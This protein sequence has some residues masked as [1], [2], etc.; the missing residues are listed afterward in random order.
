[1]STVQ[2]TR[3]IV[4]VSG[5]FLRYPGTGTGRYAQMVIDRLARSEQLDARVVTDGRPA[6][7]GDGA[8]TGSRIKWVQAPSLPDGAGQYAR[9]L[10]WEQVG[11]RYAAWRIGARV[12]YSPHFSAPWMGPGATV[13]SIHDLIPLTEPGYAEGLPARLYFKLVSA[14]ARQAA[15]VLTL[16]E[17]A[18]KDIERLLHIPAS[19][20]HVV[21]PGIDET[22]TDTRDAIAEA[23]ARSRYQL[24]PRYLLYVGGADARKNIGVLLEAMAILREEPGILPLIIAAAQPK[25]GQA[26]LFPDWRAQAARLHLGDTVRFIERI[27]EEDLATVYRM[28]SCFCFPSRAE[29]F[30]LPPLEAMACGAPVVC[31][32]TSS[33]PEAVGSAAILVPHDAPDAWARAMLDVCTN[34]DLAAG[35]GVAGVRRARLFRWDDTASKVEQIIVEAAQCGS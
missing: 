27:E 5:L 4:A 16:S 13:I 31:A 15:A 6:D 28:T 32:D 24:P 2:R 34:A 18:K 35:L 14:A 25:P 22:F 23:R 19:R 33:L 1:M 7:F 8:R 21:V 11:L 9:K 20:V 29:G 26:G 30:G 12:V 3:P 17:Y 10:Y